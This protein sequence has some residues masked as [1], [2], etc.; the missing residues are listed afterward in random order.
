M[1]NLEVCDQAAGV[2]WLVGQGLADPARV[3]IYGWSYGGYLSAMSLM[4]APAA[5]AYTR[6]IQ[7]ST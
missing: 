2:D 4:K 7:S 3:G 6:S 1:G 5:G